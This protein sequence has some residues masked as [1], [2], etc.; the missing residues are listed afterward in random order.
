MTLPPLTNGILRIDNTGMESILKCPTFAWYR[1]AHKRIP[2]SH[3]S[4]LLFGQALHAAQEY[5]YKECGSNEITPAVHANQEELIDSFF[6]DK[7]LPE[8]EWQNAA[9]CKEAIAYWNKEFKR[10]PFEVLE[11]ERGVE[12]Y[13]NT[14]TELRWCASC[15]KILRHFEIE[16][17]E[18]ECFYCGSHSSQ[19]DIH[20]QGKIDAIV[21]YQGEVMIHDYK[22]SKYDHDDQTLAKYE[23]SGQFRG[24]TWL[25][26]Q[27]GYGP[28]RQYWIDSMICRKPLARATSKAK[29]RNE[30]FRDQFRVTDV[31][32][33]EW[34]RDTL[35]TI[36]TWLRYCAASHSTPP[37]NRT[38]CA[39][40]KKCAYFGVCKID[41]MQSRLAWLGSSAFKE[42]DWNPMRKDER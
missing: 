24:Y 4:D 29:P 40:P 16:G 36:E 21:R 31:Q 27:L 7:Q 3:D 39:W 25:A 13:L 28:I 38:Q 34:K 18:E 33:E 23:V 20:Y 9:R 32:I 42:N 14:L 37:K 26:S 6:A 15:Q 2:A 11:V 5:R 30:F 35:L 10:E 22:K 41:N 12:K 19:I 1:L 17:K 8:D